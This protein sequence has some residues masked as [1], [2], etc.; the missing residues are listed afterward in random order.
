MAHVFLAPRRAP[1]P[2]PGVAA[3][4]SGGSRSAG[5]PQAPRGW[6]EGER[7]WGGGVGWGWGWGWGGG[8]EMGWW[9]T[10]LCCDLFVGGLGGWVGRGGCM[11]QPVEVWWT[12]VFVCGMFL[13]KGFL[14]AR[15]SLSVHGTRAP[16]ETPPFADVA[17]M[18]LFF[19]CLPSSFPTGD[20]WVHVGM[21]TWC[22][23]TIQ[24]GG[25]A[26]VGLRKVREAFHFRT[27]PSHAACQE[28]LE[29]KLSHERKILL[30]V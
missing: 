18:R 28:S 16:S 22:L 11:L 7:G 21:S 20:Q 12:R 13:L 25:S 17:F 14:A 19:G 10:R 24:R 29:N 8:S 27:S 6:L 1:G 30:W 4:P 26:L 5:S 15:C 23:F 2:G 9:T 3:A